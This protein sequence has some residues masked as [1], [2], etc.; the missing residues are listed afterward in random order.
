MNTAKVYHD[1]F[2]YMCMI[3]IVNRNFKI[4][5]IFTDSYWVLDE[6][7]RNSVTFLWWIYF[8]SFKE[9]IFICKQNV[10]CETQMP[11]ITAKS[12]DIQGHKDKYLDTS[13]RIL[14]Q[15]MLMC[16]MKALISIIEKLW[17][18]LNLKIMDQMSRSKGLLPTD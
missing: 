3:K 15:E 5:I 10:C 13:R 1:L 6:F 18:I 16:H 12:K 9:L 17:S 7:E 8:I 14:S 11:L 2:L 4:K